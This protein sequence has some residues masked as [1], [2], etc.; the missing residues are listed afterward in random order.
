MLAADSLQNCVQRFEGELTDGPE[1]T[2]DCGSRY[3]ESETKLAKRRGNWLG[4][5]VTLR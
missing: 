3:Q 5:S 4:E 1:L 2:A